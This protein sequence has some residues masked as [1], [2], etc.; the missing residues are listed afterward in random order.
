MVQS[1]SALIANSFPFLHVDEGYVKT[2]ELVDFVEL[3]RILRRIGPR[4]ADIMSLRPLEKVRREIY[5]GH[6]QL[7][8]L[9]SLMKMPGGSA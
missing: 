7:W 9:R 1:S 3:V 8:I 6:V 4:T 5:D 2:E